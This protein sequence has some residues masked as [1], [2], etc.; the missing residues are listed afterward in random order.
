MYS[1]WFGTLGAIAFLAGVVAFVGWKRFYELKWESHLKDRDLHRSRLEAAAY[2]EM[3]EDR[4]LGKRMP[5]I[6]GR[7]DR[8]IPPQMVEA[9]EVKA[10]DLLLIGFIPSDRHMG[11]S[12]LRITKAVNDGRHITLENH[13]GKS[14]YFDPDQFVLLWRSID[15]YM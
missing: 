4:Y 3:L 14:H 8:P 12:V 9:K 5:E 2:K 10:G 6:Y 15:V 11:K 7:D 1:V 13:G